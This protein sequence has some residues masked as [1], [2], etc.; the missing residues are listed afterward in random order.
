MFVNKHLIVQRPCGTSW[1]QTMLTVVIPQ[2]LFMFVNQH[3]IVQRPCGTS[4]RQTTLTMF[5]SLF[6]FVFCYISIQQQNWNRYYHHRTFSTVVKICWHHQVTK[7]LISSDVMYLL[8]VKTEFGSKPKPGLRFN[9]IQ[10]PILR[11]ETRLLKK[12]SVFD[13]LTRAGTPP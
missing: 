11:S 8:E 4:W 1:R 9:W 5:P 13:I 10:R 6:Q 12:A 3:I 7:Q 2:H